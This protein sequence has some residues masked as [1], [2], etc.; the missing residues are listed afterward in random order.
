MKVAVICEPPG[1]VLPV[2]FEVLGD[3][4]VI[5]S[6][7]TARRTSSRGSA[8]IITFELWGGEK[9]HSL[10]YNTQDLAWRAGVAVFE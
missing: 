4:R 3:E 10:E 5:I 1:G 7:V 9:K 8:Q 2:W 6:E